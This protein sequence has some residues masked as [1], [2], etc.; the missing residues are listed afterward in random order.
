MGVTLAEAVS[1]RV[2]QTWR[3]GDA[4]AGQVHYRADLRN[5]A[6][7]LGSAVKVG[8]KRFGQVPQ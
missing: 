1:E 2:D 4:P 5:A 7:T 3:D 6:V 8:L